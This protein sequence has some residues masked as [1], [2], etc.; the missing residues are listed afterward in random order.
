MRSGNA[1]RGLHLLHQSEAIHWSM[2]L[3]VLKTG[4]AIQIDNFIDPSQQT[5]QHLQGV[6]K[7]TNPTWKN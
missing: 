2:K 5:R 7:S 6:F 1:V 4:A 3:D